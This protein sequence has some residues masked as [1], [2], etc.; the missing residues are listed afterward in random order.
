[1]RSI[2]DMSRRQFL[3]LVGG[4]AAT[5]LAGALSE[6]AYGAGP[7][8]DYKAL[9]CVFLFGGNDAHNMI[10]PLD[11][12]YAT[13]ASNRGPLAL[14]QTSLAANAILDA[15]QGSFALHPRMARTGEL[16]RNGKLAIVSNAGILVRPTT[17]FDYQNRL[18]LPPQLFSHNDQ[19]G[20]WLTCRPQVPATT[21]WAG[22]LGDLVQSANTGQVSV[23]IATTASSIFLKG[24]ATAG[25]QVG[26]Y[27]SATPIVQRVRAYRSFD[28]AS[29]TQAVF[30]STLTMARSNI[31]EDQYG[32]IAAGAVQ[33]NDIVLNA[34]YAGPD[35]NGAYAERYAFNTAFPTDE[36]LAS[37]LRSVAMMIAAR[38]ALGVKR[39]IFFVSLGG[40]DNHSDQFDA[41][42]SAL[43]PGAADPAIM[44]GKHADLLGQLDAALKAFYDATVELGVQ[45]NVTTFTA[46]DFGRTLTSNGKGSDHGWGAHHLVMGGAVKGGKIYGTFHN[47]QVGAGN[48]A[49]AGQGRLIPDIS[50]DQYAGTMARW[51]GASSADLNVVFPNL[52]NF[53]QVDL[54][55][56]T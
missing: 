6:V 40:F 12:R 20:H 51:M 39:Q 45:N 13:Y 38:Q 17:K 28:G 30:A 50:V 32:D 15:T 21:G 7:F 33:M 46:S 4:I 43:R 52:A 54:G 26:A 19:Q 27:A 2:R 35:A 14:P 29:N 10:V 18:Q 3:R 48:P 53:N 16:Y 34:I 41:A 37:Q 31:L 5:P 55:F 44:F 42:T 24:D 11:G 23:S 49:D 36:L 22:R 8:T 25:Y 47:M 1:M 9:V 56:M